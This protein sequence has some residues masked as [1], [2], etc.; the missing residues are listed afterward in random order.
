MRVTAER[1]GKIIVVKGDRG[2]LGE[3]KKKDK[4][5]GRRRKGARNR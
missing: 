5:V 1:R 2:N 4:G 3:G